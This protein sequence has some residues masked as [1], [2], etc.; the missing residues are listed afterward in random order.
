V[1]LDDALI[2]I[3]SLFDTIVIKIDTVSNISF[4]PLM[5]PVRCQFT[6]ELFFRHC[7]NNGA[8]I[9]RSYSLRI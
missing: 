9:T 4:W 3:V 8:E 7:I 5:H 1:F 2:A 6:K